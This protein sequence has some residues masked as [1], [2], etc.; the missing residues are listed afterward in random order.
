MDPSNYIFVLISNKTFFCTRCW[1]EVVLAAAQFKAVFHCHFKGTRHAASA[2][3]ME[4][5]HNKRD[6][7][8]V[9]VRITSTHTN[10]YFQERQRHVCK[11][12]HYFP[13]LVIA[14]SVF[15]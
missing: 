9:T 5:W 4:N 8:M 3:S 12:S 2:L 10:I 6:R 14:R 11:T 13:V 1:K 15:G 7:A